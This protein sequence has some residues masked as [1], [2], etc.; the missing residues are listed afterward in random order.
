MGQSQNKGVPQNIRPKVLSRG[1]SLQG[2][3]NNSAS[4]ILQH[5]QRLFGLA[6]PLS[7]RFEGTTRTI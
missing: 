7:E 4:R 2:N 6:R 3:R 5:R 1:S